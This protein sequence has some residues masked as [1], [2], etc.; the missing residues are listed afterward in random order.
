MKYRLQANQSLL[1][2]W[3]LGIKVASA[4]ESLHA[5]AAKGT[6]PTASN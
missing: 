1:I 3:Q 4:M 5:L 6:G 2:R